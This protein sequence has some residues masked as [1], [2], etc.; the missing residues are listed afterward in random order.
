VDDIPLLVE[1]LIERYAGKSGKKIRSISKKTLE[2]FQA[3]DWPGNIREL[4]NVIERAI[5]LCEGETFTVDE[6]WLKRES[7]RIIRADR[8]L[9]RRPFRA[10]KG[11][12]RSRVSG[13]SG[14]RVRTNRGGCQTGNS[15]AD[16]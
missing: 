12:H 4:Q 7:P 5:V 16:P 9:G 8:A 14:P 13:E 10:G 11:N 6:T 1:Y 3:Y 2:L 15:Q